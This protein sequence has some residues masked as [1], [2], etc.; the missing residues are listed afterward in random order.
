VVH[1]LTW[2][3][4]TL[5]V[6]TLEGTLLRPCFEKKGDLFFF[7]LTLPYRCI[8]VSVVSDSEGVVVASQYHTVR[9]YTYTIRQYLFTTMTKLS[10]EADWYAKWG[11]C[12]LVRFLLACYLP[13]CTC[14]C[15][16]V[17]CL[18]LT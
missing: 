14:T 5:P 3:D 2:L 10:L 11:G 4:L 15:V 6:C 1:D 9:Q 16:A 13:V 7:F 17:T 12:T 8:S 18:D